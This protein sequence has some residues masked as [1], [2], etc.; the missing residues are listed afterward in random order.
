MV[1]KQKKQ[2]QLYDE[3]G[4]RFFAYIRSRGIKT[5]V[6]SSIFKTDDPWDGKP[7][8]VRVMM[9]V[10]PVV[11]AE[12]VVSEPNGAAGTINEVTDSYSP[13]EDPENCRGSPS[14]VLPLVKR[15]RRE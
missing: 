14:M 13:D 2:S 12:E 1:N 5:N 10:E 3:S 9:M 8:V 11:V 6:C 4:R 15:Q 7:V